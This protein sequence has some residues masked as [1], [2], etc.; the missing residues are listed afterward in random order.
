MGGSNELEFDTTSLRGAGTGLTGAAERLQQ[1][2][3]AL[4]STVEGMGEL[5]GDDMVGSLIGMTYGIAQEMADESFTSA[6]GEL[7]FY[8]EGLGIM[9]EAYEQTDQGIGTGM[10]QIRKEL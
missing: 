4:K 7:Q 9:A 2:W 3:E 8:G 1:Q 10:D 6:I 5:F